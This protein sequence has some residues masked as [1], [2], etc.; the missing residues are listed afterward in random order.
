LLKD[1]A[2]RQVWRVEAPAEG[3]LVV[4]D[5]WYPGWTAA[6]DGQPVPLW[7]ANYLFRAVRVPAGEHNISMTYRPPWLPV[8]TLLAGLAWFCFG[9]SCCFWRTLRYNRIV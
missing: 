6:L 4:S 2:T 9:I 1:S 5:L 7:R 8:G 3:W